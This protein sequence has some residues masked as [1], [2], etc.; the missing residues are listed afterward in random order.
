M[1]GKKKDGFVMLPNAVIEHSDLTGHELLVYI[2]LLKHRDHKTSKCHPGMATIADQAR[3][4]KKT[5]S[6]TVAALE[7]KGLIK[8]KRHKVVGSQKNDRNEYTVGVLSSDPET[9]KS[10]KETR[11]PKRVLRRDSESLPDGEVMHSSPKGRDSESLRRDSESLGVGTRSPAN[12][13]QLNK[14]HKQD[15]TPTFKES[16]RESSLL[17]VSYDIEEK[18]VTEKQVAYLKDLTIHL[19]YEAGYNVIPNEEHLNMWRKLSRYEAHDLIRSYLRELGRPDD[20]YYPE[21]GEPAYEA[22]SAAGKEFADTGGMP[23][24]V[25][26]Y[27]FA[28]KEN[29]A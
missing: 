2:V 13:N 24:S 7:V 10:A 12:K 26:E 21:F 23:D 16:G 18:H 8:V 3:M 5:A 9:Y 6:R 29:T 19:N 4:S 15:I 22:L 14:N 28:L 17:N 25:F 11:V 1:S 27:G 20:I